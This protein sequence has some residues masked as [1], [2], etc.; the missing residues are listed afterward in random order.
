MSI[1]VHSVG[2]LPALLF[3]SSCVSHDPSLADH[4]FSGPTATQS[5]EPFL[6]G[7]T[8]GTLRLNPSFAALTANLIAVSVSNI[9]LVSSF[10]ELK[11]L[12]VQALRGIP[13]PETKEFLQKVSSDIGASGVVDKKRLL[14][15]LDI[16]AQL[17]DASH[18]IFSRLQSHAREDV[19]HGSRRVN[20][21]ARLD[22]FVSHMNTARQL[23]GLRDVAAQIVKRLEVN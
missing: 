14:I 16:S 22:D 4:S 5:I 20:R 23:F 7:P 10:M 8:E 19:I 17:L 2:V 1:P 12:E 11:I 13:V 3:F 18:K 9:D 6:E 21:E 15:A